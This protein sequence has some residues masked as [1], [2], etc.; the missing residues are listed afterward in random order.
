M[1]LYIYAREPSSLLLGLLL[2]RCGSTRVPA[3][4]YQAWL[5][6]GFW[7]YELR[8]LCLHSRPSPTEPSLGSLLMLKEKAVFRSETC[9]IACSCLLGKAGVALS[10]GSRWAAGLRR[11]AQWEVLT[12]Q[13]PSTSSGGSAQQSLDTITL[14]ISFQGSCQGKLQGNLRSDRTF[15]IHPSLMS[16]LVF[17]FCSQGLSLS[18]GLV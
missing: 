11:L 6:C 10:E 4:F 12:F 5:L 15:L 3:V 14:C 7:G 13:P 17:V 8:S 18:G 2:S 9:T 16:W 1:L